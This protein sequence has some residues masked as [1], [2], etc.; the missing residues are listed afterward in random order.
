M[1]IYVVCMHPTCEYR[2]AVRTARVERVDRELYD[3]PTLLCACM[4]EPKRY[5]LDE[6]QRSKHLDDL[7]ACAV[8][9]AE[10]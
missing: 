4:T 3:W 5:T 1:N 8:P 7:L 2:G 10:T 9:T 6:I